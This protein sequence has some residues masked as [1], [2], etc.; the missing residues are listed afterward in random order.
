MPNNLIGMVHNSFDKVMLNM[1]QGTFSVGYYSFGVR[2]S[3]ILKMIIDSLNK[4]WE[5][6]FMNLATEN[7]EESKRAIINRFN[8]LVFFYM[9]IGLCVI[10]FSE[11]MIKLLTTKE[12]Y[13]SIYVVPIY[14][15]FYL[16]S[17]M[18]VLTMPQISFSEK[19]IFVLPSTFIGALINVIFNILLIPKFGALGAAGGSAIAALFS[20]LI[21]YYYAMKLFPLPLRAMKL[22]G[23]YFIIIIYT[24]FIY[25]IIAFEINVFIKIMLKIAIIS[26][27]VIIGIK[28]QFIEK[29]EL[30][31]LYKKVK[32]RN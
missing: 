9:V 25:P 15:Y 14:V 3:L 21:N 31:F 16:F 13:P 10:Y 23:L 22:A 20:Q 29:S 4:V 27:F 11:E 8:S 17:I 26:T 1:Y 12:F 30:N 2:F 19:M 6:F 7:T 5:P 32:L 18:G 24:L 28:F